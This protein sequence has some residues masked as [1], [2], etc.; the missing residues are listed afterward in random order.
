MLIGSNKKKTQKVVCRPHN[1]KSVDNRRYWD[2][3]ASVW[4]CRLCN[5]TI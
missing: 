5:C 4:Y 3:I 1:R 2:P